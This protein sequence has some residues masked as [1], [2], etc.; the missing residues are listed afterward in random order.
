[1]RIQKKAREKLR[2]QNSALPRSSEPLSTGNF[3]KMFLNTIYQTRGNEKNLIEIFFDL[4]AEIEKGICRDCI[5]YNSKEIQDGDPFFGVIYV[6][7][8]IRE[9]NLI[10]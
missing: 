3:Q 5:S 8:K 4:E 2:Q 1:M 10:F 9:Y 6:I 7:S